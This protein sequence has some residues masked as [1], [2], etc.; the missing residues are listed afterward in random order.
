MRVTHRKR[1]F[2]LA[3]LL[4]ILGLS[5]AL[6]PGLAQDDTENIVPVDIDGEFFTNT[7]TIEQWRT[8]AEIDSMRAHSWDLWYH[9]SEDSGY[10]LDGRPIPVW[11][12]WYSDVD[13]EDAIQGNTVTSA[14][15]FQRPNQLTDFVLDPLPAADLVVEF[16]KYS[17]ASAQF[18]LEGDAIS[19]YEPYADPHTLDRLQQTDRCQNPDSP[20]SCSVEYPNTS[21]NLKPVFYMVGQDTPSVLPV[22]QGI[23]PGDTVDWDFSVLADGG[24]GPGPNTWLQ[25]VVIDAAGRLGNDTTT[26]I[27]PNPDVT[28]CSEGQVVDLDE[29]YYIQL[30][31]DE[32]GRI[33]GDTKD[34][35]ILT[36]GEK[37][38]V[39]PGDYAI[40]V[41][42]HATTREID[43][44]TWQSFWWTPTADDTQ[45]IW[46]P[47]HSSAQDIV[48]AGD[49]Y[50]NWPGS[51]ANRP[52][53]LATP[54]NNYAMCTNYMFVYPAQPLSGG[55]QG[56][57]PEICF[58]PYLESPFSDSTASA[59]PNGSI[60]GGINTNCMACHSN[61]NWNGTPGYAAAQYIPRD[62]SSY[63]GP[64]GSVTLQTDFSWGLPKIAEAIATAEAPATEEAIEAEATEE[65]DD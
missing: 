43:Q 42:M 25:C 60:E 17:P 65:T 27:Q 33:Q 20:E 5:M 4:L 8:G 47:S 7:A 6:L 15:D 56:Q 63:V 28:S 19:N 40:L 59:A 52:E 62:D 3:G 10:T 44:W 41:A 50:V 38:D 61:A 2:G 58:N 51:G 11:D 49:M 48:D 12:T 46:P 13:I 16:N 18:L 36:S 29:F 9:M 39:Q 32:I 45:L 34:Y 14:R 35:V 24:S 22:W 53:Q 30:T 55:D 31:E 1:W 23:L 26:P 64:D 37:V 54:W 57:F 21:I